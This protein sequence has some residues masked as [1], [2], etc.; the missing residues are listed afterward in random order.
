LL[1]QANPTGTPSGNM[2]RVECKTCV[3]FRT[4]PDE[5]PHTGCW[6]LDHMQQKQTDAYLKQQE[7][8]GDHKRINLRGDCAQYELKPKKRSL[9]QRLMAKDF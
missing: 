4:A 9:W 1:F 5:A 3:H 2:Q 8:P 7:L 6:H